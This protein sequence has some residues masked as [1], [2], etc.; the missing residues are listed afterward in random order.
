M[1]YRKDFFH[2]VQ[3]AGS[4]ITKYHPECGKRHSMEGRGLTFCIVH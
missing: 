2:R 3:G 4:D 1:T